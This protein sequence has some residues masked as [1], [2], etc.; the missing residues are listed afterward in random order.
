MFAAESPPN[1][2]KEGN[3][4]VRESIDMGFAEG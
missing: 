4:L 2:D 3:Q 1:A